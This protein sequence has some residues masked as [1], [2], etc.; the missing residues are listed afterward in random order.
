MA[1]KG[2]PLM[3]WFKMLHGVGLL[4]I[5]AGTGL[6]VMTQI[7]QTLNGMLVVSSLL[8]IGGVMISPFPV[9]LFFRWASNATHDQPSSLAD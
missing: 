1:E 8:G 9:A 6:L 4:M 3:K 5:V 7:E 2:S